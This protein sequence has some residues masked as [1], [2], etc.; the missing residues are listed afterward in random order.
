[1]IPE[2]SVSTTALVATHGTEAVVWLQEVTDLV[3]HLPL[4]TPV[5]PQPQAPIELMVQVH[6]LGPAL[7]PAREPML[8]VRNLKLHVLLQ[9]LKHNQT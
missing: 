8:H 7:V 1:M 3:P 2:Q 5:F 9:Q 6:I 4:T